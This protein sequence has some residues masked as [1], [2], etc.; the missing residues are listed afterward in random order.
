MMILRDNTKY[1]STSDNLEEFLALQNIANC[2]ISELLEENGNN[3][4]IYPH[5]FVS[6][7]MK[8]VN[9]IYYHY[10][11]VGMANNVRRPY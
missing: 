8:Q 1:S 5:S 2:K 3:L 4:L 9:N 11:L 10:K 6:V 7:R